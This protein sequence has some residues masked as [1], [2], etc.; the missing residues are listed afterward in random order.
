MKLG[1]GPKIFEFNIKEEVLYYNYGK[2]KDCHCIFEIENQDKSF[3]DDINLC[4]LK[5]KSNQLFS[6]NLS[7]FKLYLFYNFSVYDINEIPIIILRIS[8][9]FKKQNLI[10]DIHF[11]KGKKLESEFF[12]FIKS[13]QKKKFQL[14]IEPQKKAFYLLDTDAL[15]EFFFFKIKI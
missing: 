3:F 11:L 9:F 5:E 15:K 6:L 13:F 1:D 4:K 8:N 12:F 2:K 14:Q 7:N 10:S